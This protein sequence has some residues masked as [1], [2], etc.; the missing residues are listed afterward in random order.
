MITIFESRRGIWPIYN[1]ATPW[2]PFNDDITQI[3]FLN[4]LL[5]YIWANA[6]PSSYSIYLHLYKVAT[7][8]VESRQSLENNYSW[9]GYPLASTETKEYS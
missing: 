5:K 3:S 8:N 6:L 1:L 2:L 7:P 9:P 4:W